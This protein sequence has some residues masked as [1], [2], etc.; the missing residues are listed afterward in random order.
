MDTMNVTDSPASVRTLPSVC[1]LDC[2]DTCSLSVST[3]GDRILEV[4]GSKAN[5]YTAGVIC[6]KVARSYPEFVHGADRLTRPLKRV[7]RRGEDAFEPISSWCRATTSPCPTCISR[8]RSRPRARRDER[9]GSGTDRH[10]A[11]RRQR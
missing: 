3:D 10:P 4:R 5:P 2:P 8:A 6:N 11:R 1:P 9:H 7:G